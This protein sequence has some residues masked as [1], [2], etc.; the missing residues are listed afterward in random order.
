MD[1][2][3]VNSALLHL[4]AKRYRGAKDS[5][6]SAAVIVDRASVAQELGSGNRAVTIGNIDN[7]FA[8][9]VNDGYAKSIDADSTLVLCDKI[10]QVRRP[11]NAP[12]VYREP[13]ASS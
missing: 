8:A 9:V 13:G 12:G 3:R 4:L 5:D 1:Q 7:A 10:S 11:T 2:D 6:P